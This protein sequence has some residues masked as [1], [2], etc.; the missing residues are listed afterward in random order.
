M[1][2][3]KK[4]KIGLH[5]P[6]FKIHRFYKMTMNCDPLFSLLAEARD[7]NKPVRSIT[8]SV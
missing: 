2:K 6:N 3:K 7:V 4:K 5:S 1:K 8:R